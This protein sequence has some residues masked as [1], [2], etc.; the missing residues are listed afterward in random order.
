MPELDYVEMFSAFCLIL[1]LFQSVYVPIIYA[2]LCLF[3]SAH[4][5]PIPEI[6]PDVDMIIYSDMAH[7]NES[8]NYYLTLST[9][10]N[11]THS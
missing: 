11:Y 3:L 7:T 9:V 6:P 4:S 2:V 10:H 5:F 8:H 1:S